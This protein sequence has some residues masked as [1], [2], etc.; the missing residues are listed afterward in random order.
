MDVRYMHMKLHSLPRVMVSQSNHITGYSLRAS[1][2][3]LTHPTTQQTM[4]LRVHEQQ[5]REGIRFQAT[6]DVLA[7]LLLAA[8][9]AHGRSKM[10]TAVAGLVCAGGTYMTG[11]DP[12]QW[13]NKPA[14]SFSVR[15]NEAT[16]EFWLTTMIAA[17]LP[18]C[19]GPPQLL[20]GMK[21]ADSIFHLSK[22]YY[23]CRSTSCE[24]CRG[25]WSICYRHSA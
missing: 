9:L 6:R 15:Y 22:N 25:Q 16:S 4:F 14:S 24:V 3:V 18:G 20:T 23:S 8:L 5:N 13:G 11:W 17:A 10:R 2:V 12:P 21:I 7:L 1:Q 19:D